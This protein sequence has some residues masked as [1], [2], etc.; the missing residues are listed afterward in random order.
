[1]LN[2]V[3]CLLPLLAYSF[4]QVQSAIISR[5]IIYQIIIIIIIIIIYFF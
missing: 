1:M 3:A 5:Y 4:E 2:F